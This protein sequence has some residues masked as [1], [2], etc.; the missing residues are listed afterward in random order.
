MKDY[1]F[2][3]DNYIYS[4]PRE[5]I[6]YTPDAIQLNN[7][8]HINRSTTITINNHSSQTT[9][10]IKKDDIIFINL[11]EEESLRLE[12]YLFDKFLIKWRIITL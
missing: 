11:S 6:C 7:Y 5:I 12:K 8:H 3:I 4:T 9:C 10:R 1:I 2:N